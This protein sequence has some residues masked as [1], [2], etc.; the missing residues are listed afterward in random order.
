M[1]QGYFKTG[2]HDIV[3]FDMFYRENPS[4]GGYAIACGLEQVIEYIKNLQFTPDDIRYLESV[5]LF[6][7]DFLKYLSTFRFSGSIYAVP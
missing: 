6:D 7:E 1:M 5:G 2:N 4:D 3:V